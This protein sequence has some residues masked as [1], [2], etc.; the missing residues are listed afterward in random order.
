MNTRVPM[1]T[2][3]VLLFIAL[4]SIGVGYGLWSK[5]LFIDGTVNTGSVN[6]IFFDPFTDD[7]DVMNDVSKDI[8]DTGVC[9]LYGDGS[10]DPAASGKNVARKDKD[11]GS[12]IAKLD[13]QDSQILNV[14]INNAYP[15]YFCTV[16]FHIRNTGTVPVKI[17]SLGLKGADIT[18]G[19]ITG[20]W[21][22]IL[23]G[24]QIDPGEDFMVQGDLD[25]HVEQSAPQSSTLTLEGKIQLVQWNEYIPLVW[26]KCSAGMGPCVQ[27]P[28]VSFDGNTV[29]MGELG[30]G[31]D[32]GIG[33]NMSV[34]GGAAKL[35]QG[36]S[37]DVTFQY[38][39]C[40]WDAYNLIDGPGTGYWDS[41]SVSTSPSPYWAMGYMDPVGGP[42]F[43]TN[44][45]TAVDAWGGKAYMDDIIECID[46]I[47]TANLPG[48]VG[49]TYL[50]VVLDTG[51]PD[52]ANHAH[53]SYG[54]ITVEKIVVNP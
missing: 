44:W 34:H 20:H 1:T 46:G 10:C 51:S 28:E 31:D 47:H 33:Q 3:V 41:F 45:G 16:F 13:T 8:G 38:H 37:Y 49:D 17:Q 23:V 29:I 35:P 22:E 40:T 4:A 25:L 24:R 42:N 52:Y 39:I 43:A 26:E 12:C 32:Y 15:S 18:A 19:Y 2:T 36:S 6:S 9:P 21:T 5:T 53:P 11:V 30:E 7:D 27:N 54:T 48:N 14:T 50:N